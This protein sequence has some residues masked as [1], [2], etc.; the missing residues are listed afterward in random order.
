MDFPYIIRNVFL[1]KPPN[2]S[3]VY[4]HLVYVYDYYVSLL[5]IIHNSWGF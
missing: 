1:I 3:L 4:Y 2:R 5:V